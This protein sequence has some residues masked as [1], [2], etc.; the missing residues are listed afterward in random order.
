MSNTPDAGAPRP[1][2][3]TFDYSKEPTIVVLL[4]D[5]QAM[6]GEMVRRALINDPLIVFHYCSDGQVAVESAERLHPTVILQDLMMP[7]V[8]GLDL[9]QRYRAHPSLKSV[10]VVV[11]S[12][13]EDPK[14]KGEAFRLGAT[15]YLVKLPDPVELIARIRHHSRA[16]SNQIQRDLAYQALRASQE[17]LVVMNLELQRLTNIDGLTGLANRRRMDEFLLTEWKR[18]ERENQ[19]LSIAMLDVDSFKQYN[20]TYGHLEGDQVLKA[21]ASTIKQAM[22]RP[23]D[24]AARFGGEE[25]MIILPGTD[26]MGAQVVAEGVRSAVVQL[27]IAHKTA[28]ATDCVS[29]S[30]GVASVVPRRGEDPQ[31]LIAMADAALYGAKKSGRNRVVAHNNATPN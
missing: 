19:A 15:D 4:V 5:D 14:V 17:Q 16:Y 29:V 1:S 18:A 26:V 6:V 10:P 2:A 11:L 13:K 7:Q 24:L 21:I 30:I 12:V 23:T 28:A 25:F 3:D 27:N 9:L 8:D 22:G 31:S 20:D